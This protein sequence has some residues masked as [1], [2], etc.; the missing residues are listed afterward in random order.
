MATP[1]KRSTQQAVR[2]CRHH[3]A[4]AVVLLNNSSRNPGSSGFRRGHHKHLGFGASAGLGAST[5][6]SALGSSGLGLG[7]TSAGLTSGASLRP[8]FQRASWGAE[9]LRQVAKL[10]DS[11]RRSRWRLDRW[12]RHEAAR[13]AAS[14]FPRPVSLLRRPA[15]ALASRLFLQISQTLT[16]QFNQSLQLGDILLKTCQ[17]VRW[18][19]EAPFPWR[20]DPR[21]LR[22]PTSSPLTCHRRSSRL[23]IPS[24]D[25]W[26]PTAGRCIVFHSGC[27]LAA[28]LLSCWLFDRLPVRRPRAAAS[29]RR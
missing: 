12:V 25:P 8:D 17:S 18:R 3:R 5:L 14:V 4:R 29:L 2:R 6:T 28:S 20:S 1:G 26:L 10:G 11:T 7:L 24:V 22:L 21:Q 9:R 15:A 16:L 19:R 13:L 27:D 23:S